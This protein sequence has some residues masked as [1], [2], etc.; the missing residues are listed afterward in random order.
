MSYDFTISYFPNMFILLTDYNLKYIVWK[1]LMS[2]LMYVLN[3]LGD[4]KIL[5][6]EL[7]VIV[8]EF[9]AIVGFLAFILFLILTIISVFKKNKQTKRNLILMGVSFLVFMIGIVNSGDSDKRQNE[10]IKTDKAEDNREETETSR[11]VEEIQED[12]DIEQLY[13]EEQEK[14]LLM[15]YEEIIDGSE[16]MII[17]IEQ[18]D[19]YEIIN[20]LLQDEFESLDKNRKQQL[21]DDWGNRIENNTRAILFGTPAKDF[22]FVYFK[23]SKGEHV[24]DTS[25]LDRGWRVK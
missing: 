8:V 10:V 23:N 21:I 14:Q 9:L 25:H 19:N 3:T 11:E 5:V 15:A 20:V 6:F 16:G 1:I 22:K 7:E 12:D 24:A 17:K 18:E 13:T 2:F 4:G